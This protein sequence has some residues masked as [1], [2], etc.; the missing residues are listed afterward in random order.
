MKIS[1]KRHLEIAIESLLKN[2]NPN[3]K[4][5]QYSSSA[6]IAVGLILNANSLVFYEFCFFINNTF[7]II[8]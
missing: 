7:G 2:P 3:V 6:K 5:E 1:K 4:W 8:F